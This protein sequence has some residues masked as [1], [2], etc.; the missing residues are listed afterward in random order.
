MR[1]ILHAG[2][3]KTGTTSIQKALQDNRAWLQDHGLLYPEAEP[4]EGVRPHHRFSHA[5]ATG[6][7]RDLEK[8]RRF[9]SA[10]KPQA[11]DSDAVIISSEAIYR[12]VGGNIGYAGLVAPNYWELR[13]Q[14]LRTLADLLDGFE[15]E[16]VLCFRDYAYFLAW[17]H[18]LV[19]REQVWE[20]DVQTFKEQF[21][22]RFDYDRQIDLFSRVFPEVRTYRYEEAKVEGI[23]PY[24]F[25]KIGF[26]MPP[27]ADTIWERPTKNP[28]VPV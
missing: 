19:T 16:V 23:I 1:L 25:E 15:I 10:I 13:E 12:H 22:E 4:F 7:D 24:F 6:S 18:R 5:L 8:A 3:H 2:T 27:G 9:I 26:S 20:G 11:K 21:A 28:I 14:Y 17:L